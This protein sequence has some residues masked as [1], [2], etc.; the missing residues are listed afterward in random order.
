MDKAVLK[1]KGLWFT[2]AKDLAFFAVI[3]TTF[4]KIDFMGNKTISLSSILVC[5]LEKNLH[6]VTFL[7][8]FS[9]C[10]ADHSGM[11]YNKLSKKEIRRLGSAFQAIWF[12]IWQQQQNNQH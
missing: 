3:L 5:L 12:G 9:N 4:S 1:N 8:K 11:I 10:W 6:E 2:Q 7:T